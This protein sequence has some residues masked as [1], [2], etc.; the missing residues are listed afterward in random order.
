MKHPL[1]GGACFLGT[2]EAAGSNSVRDHLFQLID[3]QGMCAILDLIKERGEFGQFKSES[4]IEGL[5]R[6]LPLQRFAGIAMTIKGQFILAG[7]LRHAVPLFQK[8]CQLWIP[9][10]LQPFF[11]ALALA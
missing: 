6:R 11:P 3:T 10:A 8:R 7:K 1:Q 2:A 9:L 5:P 4:C